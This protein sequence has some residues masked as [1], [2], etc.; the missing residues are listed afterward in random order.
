MSERD[1]RVDPRPGDVL[2]R[3][4]V[5]RTVLAVSE[6]RVF[7]VFESLLWRKKHRDS[8]KSAFRTWAKKAEV[9][10]AANV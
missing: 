9:L 4:G 1:P 3:S 8:W 5:K 7:S 10:D 6:L 2:L